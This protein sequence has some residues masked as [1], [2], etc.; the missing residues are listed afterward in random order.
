MD[1]LIKEAL[2]RIE[3]TADGAQNDR[4]ITDRRV[5]L[6]KL[7]RLFDQLRVAIKDAHPIN[8]KLQ[9]HASPQQIHRDLLAKGWADVSNH[10]DVQSRLRDKLNTTAFIRRWPSYAHRF[11]YL[12]CAPKWA[13]LCAKYRPEQLDH[14]RHAR[15]AT[16]RGLV[17]QLEA[18]H[19]PWYS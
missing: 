19:G 2:N 16:K 5:R 3:V 1:Y 7:T 9:P 15:A 6:S 13:A 11:G 8:H 17:F 10:I 14:Y 12:A 18:E 4:H